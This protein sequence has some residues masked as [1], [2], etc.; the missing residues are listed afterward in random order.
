MA[1]RDLLGA[2]RLRFLM[3]QIELHVRVAQHARTGRGAAEIRLH[4]RIDNF[5]VKILL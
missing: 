4:E 3:K 2:D 1:G 5:F